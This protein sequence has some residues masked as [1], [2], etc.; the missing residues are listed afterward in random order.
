MGLFWC[1]GVEV[2]CFFLG[3]GHEVWIVTGGS[4]RS[5]YLGF[6]LRFIWCIC[7][8][9]LGSYCGGC[10]VA[11]EGGCLLSGDVF[12]ASDVGCGGRWTVVAA[13]EAGR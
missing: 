5:S 1:L 13:V 8:A 3:D 7:G 12:S 11:A 2:G 6:V 10:F 4:S 9:V